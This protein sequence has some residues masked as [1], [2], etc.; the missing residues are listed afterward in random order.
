[1]GNTIQANSKGTSPD[2]TP[3]H[4]GTTA[5]AA[6][7][8]ELLRETQVRDSTSPEVHLS[9]VRKAQ[10]GGKRNCRTYRRIP[11]PQEYGMWTNPPFSYWTYSR[12][13]I[14]AVGSS[15]SWRIPQELS[16]KPSPPGNHIQ[17]RNELRRDLAMHWTPSRTINCQWTQLPSERLSMGAQLLSQFRAAIYGAPQLL[18]KYSATTCQWTQLPSERLS[19][20]AQLLSKLR[21]A[22]YGAPQ[23]LFRLRAIIYGVS[24]LLSKYLA[25]DCQWTQ[26]PAQCLSMG[27][28]LLSKLRAA[29]YGAPQLLFRLRATIYGAAQP[30]SK[31]LATAMPP[32]PRLTLDA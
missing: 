5:K 11:K 4:S 1:M 2:E 21:A 26:L 17:L 6:G 22:I 15:L 32:P 30:L 31:Y 23:L 29:I 8:R 14:K 12:T 7:R 3:A 19:M 16:L 18:S 13:I 9:R 24:Q 10:A 20:G 25:T 27:A 28:Q